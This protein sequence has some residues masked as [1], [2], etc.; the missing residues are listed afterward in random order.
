M[1][2]T[3]FNA[4][5]MD[6]DVAPQS[7]MQGILQWLESP[8][9]QQ[10]V[11]E[12]TSLR[13]QMT[14]L[15]ETAATPPQRARALD[16]LYTRCVAAVSSMLPTL[17]GDLTLPVPYRT[18]RV[19]ES[20]L[21]LLQMLADDLLATLQEGP[22]AHPS[23][24]STLWQSVHVLAQQ[25]MICHLI[26][27]PAPAGT[28]QRLHETYVTARRL[29]VHLAVPKG[30][31]RSLREVYHSAIL[32]G[33]AQPASLTPREVLFLA[34]YFEHFADQIEL[35]PPA[36]TA[37]PGTFLIDPARDLP[38]LSSLHKAARPATPLD[39]FSCLR[40]CLLLK[41]QMAQLDAG[42]SPTALKL[43]D[44]AGTSAGRGVLGRLA[45]RWGDPGKR[46]FLRRRQSQRMILGAGIDGLWELSKNG[47]SAQVELSDWMITNESPDGYAVMHVSGETGALSV[48]DVAAVRTGAEQNWQICLVRW[49]VSENP[50]HLELGL[51][52]LAP[53]AVPAILAQPSATSG[54]EHL[55]VLILPE[56]PKLRSG[57]SLVV[58]ADA[59]PKDRKRLLLVID[60]ENVVVREVNSTCVDEQTGSVEILS[61]EPDPNP[62]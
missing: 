32:L 40:L 50:E 41:A 2:E 31:A 45:A 53:K 10:P 61:I 58:A 13:S 60:G 29:H 15:H 44:F 20:T 23:L 28:W 6:R 12:I 21:D 30:R 24:E 54:T 35:L 39:C 18:R 5:G 14:A 43:P 51:Q 4:A 9:A 37:D 3:A 1:T 17:L 46:R 8:I 59:L 62:F 27:S 56:I 19:V 16:G 22:T 36:P 33:C 38:A 52:I 25:L 49:A 11:A 26:A 34:T 47:E 42:I 48:G 55:R 7:G 57:Q